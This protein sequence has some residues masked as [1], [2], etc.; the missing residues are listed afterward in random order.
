MKRSDPTGLGFQ[1]LKIGAEAYSPTGMGGSGISDGFGGGL[2]YDGNEGWGLYVFN[3]G[4]M[5]ITQSNGTV[6]G[7]PANRNGFSFDGVP[8]SDEWAASRGQLLGIDPNEPN[9]DRDHLAP[10][11]VYVTHYG[12]P[13]DPD[14]DPYTA[15]WQGTYGALDDDSLA[16]GRDIARQYGLTPGGPVYVNGIYLGNYM[17]RAPSVTIDIFDP[18]F[19]LHSANWGGNWGGILRSGSFSI[20]NGPPGG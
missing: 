16:I 14:W 19:T 15:N 6:F 7:G 2:V 17:D 9:S 11:D 3:Q 5:G 20:S 8:V 10:G 12:Y 13:G 4:N 18:Y 1:V